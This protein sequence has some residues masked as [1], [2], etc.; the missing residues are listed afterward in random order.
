MTT[1]APLS[2]SQPGTAPPILTYAGAVRRPRVLPVRLIWATLA[3]FSGAFAIACLGMVW[4]SA[5]SYYP[6]VYSD[7]TVYHVNRGHVGFLYGVLG[8]AAC[9]FT[10]W[11]AVHRRGLGLW[12]AT[13]RPALLCAAT[14]WMGV[15]MVMQLC[16]AAGRQQVVCL[17]AIGMGLT[18]FL[19]TWLLRGPQAPVIKHDDY[20]QAAWAHL[21]AALAAVC[22]AGAVLSVVA[23]HW[24]GHRVFSARPV[25]VACEIT[26]PWRPLWHGGPPAAQTVSRATSQIQPAPILAGI[27]TVLAVGAFNEWRYRRRQSRLAREVLLGD[28]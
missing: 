11:K 23:W 22:V 9:I 27:C 14:A 8:G 17:I 10:T 13:V 19:T 16:F 4:R 5:P 15:A 7:G 1:A 28:G 6:L 25:F 3:I 2:G 21:F 12:R 20:W 24:T 26:D 18:A